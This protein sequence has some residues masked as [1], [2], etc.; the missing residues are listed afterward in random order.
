MV[1]SGSA[2]ATAGSSIEVL[3]LFVKAGSELFRYQRLWDEAAAHFAP[4]ALARSLPSTLE[5]CLQSSIWIDPGTF[6]GKP[7]MVVHTVALMRC[8]LQEW[9]RENARGFTLTSVDV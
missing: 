5:L 8:M 9:A 6:L 3:K 2:P 1:A 4:D 7:M